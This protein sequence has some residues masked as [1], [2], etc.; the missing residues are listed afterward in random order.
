MST[1]QRTAAVRWVLG[2][3]TVIGSVL[4]FEQLRGLGAQDWVLLGTLAVLVAFIENLGVRVSYG[5]VTLMPV[6][7]L[8][9]YFAFGR[10]QALAVIIVGSVLG[11]IAQIW[12]ANRR[13]T[14][15]STPWW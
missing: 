15:R 3:T 9:A 5:T 11:G 4:L 2:I 10:E 7:V 8:M 12:M 13:G 1:E 14:D 6:T